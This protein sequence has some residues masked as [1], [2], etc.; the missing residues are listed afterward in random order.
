MLSLAYVAFKPVLMENQKS[1]WNKMRKNPLDR[2]PNFSPN[3][4]D[5]YLDQYSSKIIL[6]GTKRLISSSS[7]DIEIRMSN[8]F[9]DGP[10]THQS[11]FTTKHNNP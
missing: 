8:L 6:N 4:G 3:F 10:L 1:R 2:P 7:I 9:F 11:L 5:P